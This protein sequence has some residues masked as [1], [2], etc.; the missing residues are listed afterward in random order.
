M[1]ECVL[2]TGLIVQTMN[3]LTHEINVELFILF[4]SKIDYLDI[5]GRMLRLF[6]IVYEEQSVTKA[7]ERL[8]I[9]QS[10]VSHM[11][12]KWRAITGD[13]LFVRAGRGIIATTRAGQIA[14]QIRPLLSSLQDLTAPEAFDPGKLDAEVTIGADAHQRELLLP[15]F[16]KLLRKK[17]PGIDLKIINSGVS[18]AELLRKEGCDLLITPN[19]PE[20]MEFVQQKLFEDHWVCF[21]D[22]STPPPATLDQYLARPHVKIVFSTNEH[23]IIDAILEEQGKSR[24]IALRV[25]SFSALSSMM[26]GTDLVIALPQRI[27]TTFM[28][29]FASC[30]LPFRVSPLSFYMTWHLETNKSGFHRWL[31]EN[32]KNVVKDLEL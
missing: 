9:G 27:E 10:A 15:T 29:G 14:V 5:S 1:I 21:Y 25:A 24:R 8:N 7:A 6:L 19:P 11:L 23:S 22:A 3:R 16:A 18:S 4:M 31:R 32:L 13:P 17:A 12:E 20:G 26:R 2:A 30:P 28:R